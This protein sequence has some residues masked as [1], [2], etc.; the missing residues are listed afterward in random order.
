MD[1]D[2]NVIGG[3]QRNL[4]LGK[5]AGAS[6]RIGLY[7]ATAKLRTWTIASCV[8]LALDC[9]EGM[10]DPLPEWLRREADLMSQPAAYRAVHRPDTEDEVSA[11]R[12]RVQFDEAF[13]LQLA[14]V[15]GARWRRRRCRPR[16]RVAGGLLDA[17]DARLP[18]G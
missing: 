9:L 10:E 14:M 11:G 3:A 16:P 7:P 2:G 8:S 15:G 17:F 1:E 13:G 6:G 18:F 5:V 4:D 12:D